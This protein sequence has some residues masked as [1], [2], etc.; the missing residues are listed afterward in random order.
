MQHQCRAAAQR[1]PGSG[2]APHEVFEQ[3]NSIA[4]EGSRRQAL[5]QLAAVTALLDGG[6]R[7]ACYNWHAQSFMQFFVSKGYVCGCRLMQPAAAEAALVQ[8][9]T[10]RLKN[11]Y[12]LVSRLL[13]GM[14]PPS[15]N[16]TAS[17][18]RT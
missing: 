6:H 7:C 1:Q 8:F 12:I 2:H 15:S 10:S 11:R 3:P 5:L 18:Q 16:F 9:P 17:A 4:H 13:S 14:R